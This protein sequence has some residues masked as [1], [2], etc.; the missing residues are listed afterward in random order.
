MED[1][2]RRERGSK[3]DLVGSTGGLGDR[4]SKWDLWGVSGGQVD[5]AQEVSWRDQ[6]KLVELMG[7]MEELGGGEWQD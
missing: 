2:G 1:W 6:G 4:G 3:W 7:E 5:C